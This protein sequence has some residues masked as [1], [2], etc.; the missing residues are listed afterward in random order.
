M[1]RWPLKTR[2]RLPRRRIPKDQW[3]KSRLDAARDVRVQRP[4]PVRSCKAASTAD[5]S[6]RPSAVAF[7]AS[8]RRH[9]VRGQD[10]CGR[11][12]I[13]TSAFTNRASQSV[14]S[15]GVADNPPVLSPSLV[16][17]GMSVVIGPLPQIAPKKHCMSRPC[18]RHGKVD[19]GAAEDRSGNGAQ[20]PRVSV[21]LGDVIV[22]GESAW[23][24][25]AAGPISRL[26]E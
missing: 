14:P 10:K 16:Q 25:V 8:G 24:F 21:V 18:L 17:R 22:I 23:R 11:S 1:T 15:Q 2:W 12:A 19:V 4:K 20:C 13:P 3:P 5:A 6:P 7:L 9:R 26:R